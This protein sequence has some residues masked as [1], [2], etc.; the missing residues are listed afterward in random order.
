M[1]LI[2][3]AHGIHLIGLR[4]NIRCG[5]IGRIAALVGA[6][7]LFGKPYPHLCKHIGAISPLNANKIGG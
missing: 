4:N 6:K 2:T 1:K 3:Q 7:A 5:I